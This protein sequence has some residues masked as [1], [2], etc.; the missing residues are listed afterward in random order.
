MLSQINNLFGGFAETKEVNGDSVVAVANDKKSDYVNIRENVGIFPM[1]FTSYYKIIGDEAEEKLDYLLTKSV[2]Y[3]NYGQNR[4][5][6]FLKESGEIAAFITLYKND[7]NFMIETFNWS[8]P[9]VEAIL[10]EHD[11]SFEKLNNSCILL[12]GLNT[13]SFMADSMELTVD[14]FVYQS[15]QDLDCFGKE[16]MI[17]RTGYTGEF[18]YKLI[19]D[20]D[21]IQF[22]WEN[23]L[24]AH[25]DK[26]VG[27][28]AF[29]MCQYEIKQ[30]FWT[31]PYL[32]LS[33]NA[34]E[35]DY[36]W[37]VDFKKDIDYVGKDALLITKFS[38][39]N[40][41]M[42]GATTDTEF[43]IGDDVLLEGEVIGRI[44]DSRL[45]YG[46]GKYIT[47]LFVVK[48][49]AH[50]NV[51]METSGGQKLKTISAPYIFPAS[52]TVGR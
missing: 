3:L 31:L 9:T 50:A 35:V 15:H 29:E 46:L 5:C 10:Q 40:E 6:L 28:D 4:F 42:I 11:V 14:Y 37:L 23:L 43:T 41:R 48:E 25:K 32:A 18:G 19:G 34:F 51:D 27:F 38:E 47:M 1:T 45:S 13:V 22:I 17:A 39:A 16:V 30:P 24:P 7:E 20:I 8:T 33:N 44:V 2:Q 21:T 12:E 52:W 26:V 49:Y 36:H